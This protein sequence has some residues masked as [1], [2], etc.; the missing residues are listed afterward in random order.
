MSSLKDKSEYNNKTEDDSVEKL[1]RILKYPSK[2]IWLRRL[3]ERLETRR[4]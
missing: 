1:C 4:G 2:K 3:H